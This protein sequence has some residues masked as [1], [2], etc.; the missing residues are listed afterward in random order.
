MIM[1][2]IKDIIS[3]A[4][5]GKMFIMID[6]ESREN[7]GDL[8]I[9][10]CF[11]SHQHINFM[12]THGKG[13]VCLSLTEERIKELELPMMVEDN[14]SSFGT[15]F[16]VSIGAKDGITSGISALDRSKTIQTAIY[17]T[18]SDIV[19]P[20]H[21]FPL[22]ANSGGVLM[23]SGHTEA[24]IDICKLANLYPAGV[25]CEIIKEDGTMARKDDLIAF[26]KKHDLLFSTIEKLKKYIKDIDK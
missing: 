7:E 11:I 18:K 25:I 13:L 21:V 1:N 20:G 2:D 24:I 9:P 15:N 12:I 14:R 8:M 3:A 19:S 6:D 22:K 16:T 5:L 10:A 26:A 17:G 4:K 23:R